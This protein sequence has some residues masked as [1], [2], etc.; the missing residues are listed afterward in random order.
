M[1]YNLFTIY[2]VN[3]SNKIIQKP[4]YDILIRFLLPQVKFLESIFV[5]Q[6]DVFW[7]E[8]SKKIYL[9][10]C[11]KKMCLRSPIGH[12]F[13][14]HVRSPQWSSIFHKKTKGPFYLF[15][16]ITAKYTWIWQVE[17]YSSPL[18][19]LTVFQDDWLYTTTYIGWCSITYIYIYNGHG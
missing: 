8:G 7:R 13:F 9:R 6:S 5:T 2:N 14:F 18:S 17:K 19:W 15:F 4:L 10:S 3:C 11:A 16:F 1:S 12:R